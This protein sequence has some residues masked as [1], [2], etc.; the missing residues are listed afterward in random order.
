MKNII[1]GHQ[2][3]CLDKYALKDHSLFEVGDEIGV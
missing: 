3:D 2:R 1:Y